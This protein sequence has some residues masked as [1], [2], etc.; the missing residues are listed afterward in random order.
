MDD[1]A[2]FVTDY[3]NS[4]VSTFPAEACHQLTFHRF[5]ASWQATGL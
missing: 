5:W 3:I 4:D 1:V 2:D